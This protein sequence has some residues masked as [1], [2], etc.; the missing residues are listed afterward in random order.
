MT[1]EQATARQLELAKKADRTKEENEELEALNKAIAEALAKAEKGQ[2][3]DGLELATMTTEEFAR[4]V[5]TEKASDDSSRLALLRDNIAAVTRQMKSGRDVFAVRVVPEP[6]ARNED[7]MSELLKSMRALTARIDAMEKGVETD[8]RT[9]S[10]IRIEDDEQPVDQSADTKPDI[11]APAETEKEEMADAK[12]PISQALASEALDKLVTA[13][14]RLKTLVDQGTATYEDMEAAFQH[15]WD[16]KDAIRNAL[17]VMS[18]ASD[19]AAML[20]VLSPRLEEMGL[21]KA[22][23]PEEE[24]AEGDEP[25]DAAADA[26]ADSVDE[27]KDE[28]TEDEE[29]EDEDGEEDDEAEKKKDPVIEEKWSGDLAPA[30]TNR[31]IFEHLKKNR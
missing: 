29:A 26:A 12:S 16:L 23:E 5:E 7:I 17:A 3:P 14:S 24:K 6:E 8:G 27:P 15:D 22:D 21:V 11:E 19:L 18:K 31:Q 20:Q 13:Y 25:K 10:G 28:P 2:L 30:M 9:N 1:F 4:Y